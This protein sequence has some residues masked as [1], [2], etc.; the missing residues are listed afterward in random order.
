MFLWG[1]GL[2]KKSFKEK[3]QSVCCSSVFSIN[4]YRSRT[5]CTIK[6][7]LLRACRCLWLPKAICY[8]SHSEMYANRKRTSE[9]LHLGYTLKPSTTTKLQT[10]TTCSTR[11]K[12]SNCSK[13]SKKK[14]ALLQSVSWS[15]FLLCQ[16]NIVTN[17]PSSHLTLQ[18]IHTHSALG[19]LQ[20]SF[21]SD[22]CSHWPGH[23]QTVQASLFK[24]IFLNMRCKR[25]L[26]FSNL[27]I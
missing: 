20:N 25:Q 15:A 21:W 12:P 19:D 17:L 23:K 16:T 2:G 11:T 22:P 14:D 4:T 27:M 7:S 18:Q 8:T 3:Q 6:Y 1:S 10:P 9:L 5:D 26:I 13:T 24:N